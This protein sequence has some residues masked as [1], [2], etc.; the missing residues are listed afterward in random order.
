MLLKTDIGTYGVRSR[1]LGVV[2]LEEGTDSPS[3]VPSLLS[4]GVPV[5]VLAL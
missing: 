4:S 1:Y 5:P 2:D 3:F